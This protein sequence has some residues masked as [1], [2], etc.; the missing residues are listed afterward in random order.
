MI[1]PTRNHHGLRRDAEGCKLFPADETDEGLGAGQL[2]RRCLR[3]AISYFMRAASAVPLDLC[4]CSLA[5]DWENASAVARAFSIGKNEA[6]AVASLKLYV[7]DPIVA[8]LTE[9]V[10]LRGM[11]QFLSHEPIA[12]GVFNRGFTS[13]R[14]KFESWNVQLTNGDDDALV[15]WLLLCS[16][17]LLSLPSLQSAVPAHSLGQFVP[18]TNHGRLR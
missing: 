11:R 3:G 1:F 2:R 6:G 8:N 5:E 14:D 4:L 16:C 13:G 12:R 9:A 10:R 7:S 17:V 15:S 18:G